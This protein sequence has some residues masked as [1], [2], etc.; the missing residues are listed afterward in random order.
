M[1]SRF[2]RWRRQGRRNITRASTSCQGGVPIRRTG[3]DGVPPAVAVEGRPRDPAEL[4]VD[5][6]GF[7]HVSSVTALAEVVTE[8][9]QTSRS[10]GWIEKRNG[11][12]FFA[13]W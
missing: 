13:E 9:L 1:T 2:E 7:G 5:R 10:G 3:H 12:E 6:R 11:D 4:S 8:K